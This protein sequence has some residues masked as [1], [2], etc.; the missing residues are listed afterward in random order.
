M[1]KTQRSAETLKTA[2]EK[3]HITFKEVNIKISAYFPA[4]IVAAIRW[5]RVASKH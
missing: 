3:R 4:Q 5:D 2:T 1:T